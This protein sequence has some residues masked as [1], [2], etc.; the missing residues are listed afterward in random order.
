MLI[1]MLFAFLFSSGGVEGLVQDISKPV[2][3]HVQDKAA[4]K[5][6]LVLNEEMRKE[7]AALAK[8]IATARKSLAKLNQNRLTSEAEL[9]A[10]FAEL[11]Q[12]RANARDKR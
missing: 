4:M 12:K 1:A 6:I 8:D 10:V 2:K 3:Q 5:Q 11:E 7:D 9:A